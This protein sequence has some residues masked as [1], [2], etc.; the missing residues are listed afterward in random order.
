MA[1]EGGEGDAEV[2]DVRG[3]AI[4]ADALYDDVHGA[5]QGDDAVELIPACG[6]D[7]RRYALIAVGVEEHCATDGVG[8]AVGP[9]LDTFVGLGR[10]RAVALHPEVD[11][12][13]VG[14]RNVELRRHQVSD[15][16]SAHIRQ[17]HHA[18]AAVTGAAVRTP[19]LRA[20]AADMT[21]GPAGGSGAAGGEGLEILAEGRSPVQ[22]DGLARHGEA[23]RPAPSQGVAR[24]ADAAHI[25][26][27]CR[28][29]KPGGVAV[30]VGV[31]HLAFLALTHLPLRGGAGFPFHRQLFGV[32]RHVGR[33]GTVGYCLYA[34]LVNPY[35]AHPLIHTLDD[36][37]LLAGIGYNALKIVPSVFRYRRLYGY[38]LRGEEEQ[39]GA[40]GIGSAV[41]KDPHAGLCTHRAV[42]DALEPQ[43]HR[44]CLRLRYVE[45]RTDQV[46]LVD[47]TAIRIGVRHLGTVKVV[48]TLIALAPSRHSA[49]GH[50]LV[51]RPTSRRFVVLPCVEEGL[52]EGMRS[53]DHHRLARVALCATPFA[54]YADDDG[55]Q[56]CRQATLAIVG[57]R[58][59]RIVCVPA[60]IGENQ[61]LEGPTI[62]G[63]G[64]ASLVVEVHQQVAACVFKRGVER[65]GHILALDV[66]SRCATEDLCRR[67][68]VF[69]IGQVAPGGHRQADGPLPR[70]GCECRD[71]SVVRECAERV[72]LQRGKLAGRVDALC[73]LRVGRVEGPERHRVG[74]GGPFGH[75]DGVLGVHHGRRQY[76][77][78]NGQSF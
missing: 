14:L 40:N 31:D 75:R 60:G 78:R 17:S 44:V 11:L 2:V 5:A 51:G 62:L 49:A 42:G 33:I 70:G 65:K 43:P 45:S 68:L 30:A 24:A 73:P 46:G 4:L 55:G 28:G 59:A 41:H 1:A 64:R 27:V 38:M 76:Q 67:R 48:V 20:G 8:R 25:D 15:G 21:G 37:V 50:M 32:P 47:G 54:I 13:A 29:G 22:H 72:P 6:C 16:G 71:R 58:V 39:G 57:R 12:V 69:A 7:D 35:V 19:Q 74:T 61:R 10:A 3:V 77:Q 9:Y 52:R 56:V 26:V 36:D 23:Y 18:T 66:E 34:E 63:T 53:I